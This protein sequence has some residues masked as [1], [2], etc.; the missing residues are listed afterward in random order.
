MRIA[1]FGTPE[2]ALAGLKA[3]LAHGMNVVV[4]ITAP[5][6]PAGRGLELK[7]SPVKQFAVDKQIPVLQPTN[8]KDAEFIQQLQSFNADLGIIIAFRMLPEAVWNMFPKG[9]FNIHASLLPQ[10]RGAAPINHAIINGEKETG[11]TSFFLKHEIDTG[12]IIA[13]R[14]T[15]IEEN[16]TAGELH[17]R[18]MVMG[19]QLA[20]DT[21]K[22][23]EDGKVN[24]LAQ[25]EVQGLRH[26]PKIFKDF[27]KIDFNKEALLVHNHI[28]GLSPYPGAYTYINIDGKISVLKIY[29]SIV[30][31]RNE[32]GVAG[33]LFTDNKTFIDVRCAEGSISLLE[34]QLEGKKKVGIKDFLNGI[35]N[36]KS[37]EIS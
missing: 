27:C 16:E 14:K 3:L 1:Y 32:E 18:L 33:E 17:D 4:V 15:L 31:N 30:S 7:A 13:S 6:K 2:F 11:V 19:A 10:Y 25:E 23:I 34:L 24:P 9:T 12:S 37:I 22:L 26:A 8:L 20:V 28:R 5:D 36:C 35:K 29:R 21:V